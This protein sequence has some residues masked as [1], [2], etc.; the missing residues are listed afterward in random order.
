MSNIAISSEN[1]SGGQGKTTAIILMAT[2]LAQQYPDKD[3]LIINTDPQ[4]DCALQLGIDNEVE[5]RCLTQYVLGEKKLTEVVIPANSVNGR[6]RPNLFYIPAGPNFAEAVEQMQE[7][8]GVMVDLY[9]RLS[10]Q[11]RKKQEPPLSPAH[12]FLE[13]L[14]PL[15]Q[16]GPAVIFVDCPP[17]LGP[18][19][20]MVHWF[21]D[22]VVVPVIPGAKEVGMTFKHTREISSD[23]EAGAG[24]K[25]LAVVPNQFDTRLRL[26]QGYLEQLRSVYNGLLW[27]PIPQ[28]TAVGQ[29][30]ATGDSIMEVAPHNDVAVGFGRLAQKVAEMAKL[31]L[32]EM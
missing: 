32:R 9:G 17:S 15:K 10:A 22:Y 3:F 7:D 1:R 20:Q 14:L 18:L 8:Y 30:A 11:A 5:D 13:A 2:A 16:R 28:R 25:I 12:Q 31:P 4:N 19:R 27:E 26:H 24:A 29:A 6:Q 23:I 21:V